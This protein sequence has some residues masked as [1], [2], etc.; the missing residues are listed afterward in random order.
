MT[1][2][3]DKDEIT[4][5][6]AEPRLGP[7]TISTID[8]G[9]FISMA[10]VLI[11]ICSTLGLKIVEWIPALKA[12]STDDL[13]ST[14]LGGYGLQ[15]GSILAF[16]LF[17]RLVATQNND[18][19]V[20]IKKAISVGLASLVV[21]YCVLIAFVPLWKLLLQGLN[22]PFEIQE[23]VQM[24]LDGGSPLEMALMYILIVV[25]APLG[26]ELLFRGG[27]FRFLNSRISM[28]YAAIASSILFGLVHFN[29]YSFGPLVILGLAMC[30]VYY[31]TGSL[32]ANITLHAAFNLMNLI[33]ISITNSKELV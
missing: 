9:L 25:G 8:F 21:C 28:P 17:A 20:P 30:F 3:T 31:K 27:I 5:S 24:L 18:N 11:F 22:I 7:W 1:N 16:V 13:L 33:F 23:P 2:A 4:E 29:V 14:I 10:L 6:S 15:L 19:P 26:E 12:L 32:F